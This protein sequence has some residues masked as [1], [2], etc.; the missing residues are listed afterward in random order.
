MADEQPLLFSGASSFLS[1]FSNYPILL[2]DKLWPTTEHYFQAQKF[3][4]TEVE[5]LIREAASPAD[6]KQMG[7]KGGKHKLRSNWENIKEQIM[8]EALLAKFTQHAELRNKLL[9]TGTP[10]ST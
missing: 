8:Y 6:A 5:E 9:D 2:R 10:N 7:G 4:G 3:A 1:N